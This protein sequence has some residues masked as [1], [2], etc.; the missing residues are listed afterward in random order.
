MADTTALIEWRERE[1]DALTRHELYAIL[2]ARSEAFVVEQEC[3]FLDID[4]R[5]DNAWHLAGW[6]AEGELRAYAR[7]LG[8]DGRETEPSIGRVLTTRNARG[9]GLGR[10]LMQHAMNLCRRVHGPGPVRVAA[11]QRLCDFYRS[12]G[13]EGVGDP[14]DEDGIL[15]QDMIRRE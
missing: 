11:Q 14:Y 4:G 7:I 13:F 15:H 5:D 8:P 3:V 2:A 10:L 1:F 6:S 12:L 9:R